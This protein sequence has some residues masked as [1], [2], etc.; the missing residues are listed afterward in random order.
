[1]LCSVDIPEAGRWATRLAADEG[2][3]DRRRLADE[4]I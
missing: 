1:M 3:T 4:I 2:V